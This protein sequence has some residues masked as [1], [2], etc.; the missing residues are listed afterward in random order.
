[1]KVYAP[2]YYTRFKCIADKCKHSCCVGWEIDIDEE[3]VERYKRLDGS[4]GERVRENI[5]FNADDPHFITIDNEKCP[6]LNECGL[7]D[8][9]IN[10]GED[11]LC[12]MCTYHPRFRNFFS[13]RVEIGLG[14][15]C[16]AAAELIL[17]QTHSV[18]TV[19]LEES[20]EGLE[21]MGADE[22]EFFEARK[23][24]IS[25]IQNRDIPIFQ[26][27][28]DVQSELGICYDTDEAA[29]VF[30]GL[31]YMDAE[32][33][34]TL[35]RAFSENTAF[36]VKE[37]WEIPLEQL[38]VYFIMRHTADGLYG[39]DIPERVAFCSLCAEAVYRVTVM[40]MKEE[41][42][43]FFE[44]LCDTARVFSSEIEYSVENTDS[45]IEAIAEMDL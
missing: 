6:F 24:L 9:I 34:K 14:L 21:E 42:L 35:S 17:S 38:A 31:E 2:D 26:R 18:K 28:L 44:T 11:A 3:S 7:C 45:L 12:E 10:L 22:L 5:S 29:R 39:D 32:F 40:R 8:I 30:D 16:E 43:P 27:L 19:E 41:G 13:D 1:M 36:E 23:R 37:E 33:G 25:V 20:D 15:C 4:F